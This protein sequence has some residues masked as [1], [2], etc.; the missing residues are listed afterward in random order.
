MDFKEICIHFLILLQIYCIYCW[1][2]LDF[3]L[4]FVK[5]PPETKASNRFRFHWLIFWKSVF[6][7]GG[8]VIVIIIHKWSQQFFIVF[9]PHKRQKSNSLC[10]VLLPHMINFKSGPI[11]KIINDADVQEVWKPLVGPLMSE[12]TSIPSLASFGVIR[13]KSIF[14]S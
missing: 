1:L 2:R 11:E 6:K 7:F 3:V 10:L 9:Q 4:K 12:E 14:F 5:L 13:E 8:S